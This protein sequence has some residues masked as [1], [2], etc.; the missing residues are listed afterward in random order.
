MPPLRGFGACAIESLNLFWTSLVADR[1]CKGKN[2]GTDWGGVVHFF[3]SDLETA[4]PDPGVVTGY[5]QK[6][7]KTL[8]KRLFQEP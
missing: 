3:S 5:S 4:R 2:S 1:T 7:W 6:L 8:W